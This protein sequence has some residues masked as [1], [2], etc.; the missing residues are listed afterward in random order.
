LLVVEICV[1]IPSVVA[2]RP[3]DVMMSS[4]ALKVPPMMTT[5]EFHEWAGDG[6]GTRYELVDGLLRAM[7]PA[8]DAHGTIH[9]N[10]SYAVTSHLRRTRPGCRLVVAPGV[11]PRTRSTWNHRIP[12]LGV[13]CQPSRPGQVMIPDPVLLVEILS[14][15]NK[16][17]TW[18]NIPLY[19]T[20][21]SVME[22]LIVESTTVRAELL[23][24]QPDGNWPKDPTSIERHG[25]ITLTSIGFEIPIAALY[26]DTYLA[27]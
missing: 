21:P 10:I 16:A 2:L 27:D 11:E 12:E 26:R 3:E 18:S 20:V 22:I 13:T 17:D 1:L 24:R 19:A 7:A 9:N 15:G 8:S 4:A 25:V 6:T 14:P 5:A 23:R